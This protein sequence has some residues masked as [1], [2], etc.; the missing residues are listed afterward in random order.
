MSATGT[1]YAISQSRARRCRDAEPRE[2]TVSGLR[3]L[4]CQKQRIAND[5]DRQSAEKDNLPARRQRQPR[6]SRTGL[7]HSARSETTRSQALEK[8]VSVPLAGFLPDTHKSP[9]VDL[10]RAGCANL[11]RP[12]ARTLLRRL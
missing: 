12:R 10:A 6:K 2:Q 9:R 7:P 1:A 8:S 11:G 5:R 4:V 3:Q